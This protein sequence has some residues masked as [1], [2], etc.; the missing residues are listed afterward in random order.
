MGWKQL[1]IND[2]FILIHIPKTGGSSIKKYFFGEDIIYHKTLTELH[3]MNPDIP[4]KYQIFSVVRNPYSRIKSIY[5]HITENK[6]R[7]KP[8]GISEN[9]S[10]KV[11]IKDGHFKKS[12]PNNFSLPQTD[13]LSLN[14]V[15]Y[16][17]H[18]IK[19]ENIQKEITKFAKTNNIS[20]LTSSFPHIR[21]GTNRK[22]NLIDELKEI[23]YEY[24]KDDFLNFN[25]S[26]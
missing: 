7:C 26:K 11:F 2:K 4:K 25:Y 19:F 10:F 17:S 15:L 21:A 20:P 8:Y 16:D 6:Y 9:I 3:D 12:T 23:V 13:Y 1:L 18:I 5:K 24:Y 14:G 22:S